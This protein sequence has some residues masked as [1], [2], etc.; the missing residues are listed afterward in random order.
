MWRLQTHAG[1]SLKV[2]PQGLRLGRKE[3]CDVVLGDGHASGLHAVLVPSN[4]GLEFL[5]L[6][7]NPCQVNSTPVE[8]RK[9]LKDGDRVELPGLRFV[10]RGRPEAGVSWVLEHADLR[11]RL[12]PAP[13][14]LGGGPDDTLQIVDWPTRAVDITL[15]HGQPVAEIRA[16]MSLHAELA[17]PAL[18]QLVD[19]DVLS[20][21]PGVVTVRGVSPDGDQ[22]LRSAILPIRAH[23]QFLP[24]GGLLQLGFADGS[25][26]EVELPELRARLVAALLKPA[27]EYEGG[28]LIPDEQLLKAVWPGRNDRDRTDLNTLVHRAR[29]ELLRAGVNPTPILVRARGGGATRFRVAHGADIG[30]F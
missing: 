14:T 15:V 10:V 24:T 21:G 17:E 30:V 1:V 5:A 12:G 9:T 19:G 26:A 3:D 23:F 29:K 13:V 11:Y 27:G 2:P 16:G 18:E 20:F 28:E 8:G 25:R 6:G 7:R 4:R 22:T